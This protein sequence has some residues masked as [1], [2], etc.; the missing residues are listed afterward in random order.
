[1]SEQKETDQSINDSGLGDSLIVSY[2]IAKIIAAFL[3]CRNI[4]ISLKLNL[5]L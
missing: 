5:L 2:Y 1:M 4:F 3:I